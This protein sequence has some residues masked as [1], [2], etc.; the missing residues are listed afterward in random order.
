VEGVE[1]Q[2]RSLVN[3]KDYLAAKRG[4]SASSSLS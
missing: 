4:F 1:H 3:E 2:I